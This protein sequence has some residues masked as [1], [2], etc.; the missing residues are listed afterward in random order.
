MN[1]IQQTLII[2]LIS[3]LSITTTFAQEQYRGGLRTN[4]ST[5]K[6]LP[7][8]SEAYALVVATDQYDNFEDLNNPIYDAK[9]VAEVLRNDYDF[10]V[11]LLLSPS[12]EELLDA[13]REYHNKLR[14]NDRFMLYLAGHGDYEDKYYEEGFLI[15]KETKTRGMD[16]SLISYLPFHRLKALTENLPSQQALVV[17]DVCFGGAF[18]DKINKGRGVSSNQASISAEDFLRFQL[19]EKNRYVL[20]SG[21][22]TAVADGKKGE[23]SPFAGAF[24]NSLKGHK[25]DSIV[26]AGTVKYDLKTL[27]S[28][29]I[30]GS[31]SESV[32]NT[33]FVFKS[34]SL[35]TS[36][37]T[38]MQ[39]AIDK[40]MKYQ[41]NLSKY[42]LDEP[43][44]RKSKE[45]ETIAK[46]FDDAAVDEENIEAMFW[47]L[48]MENQHDQV[49]MTD[50]ERD[51]FS[52][53]VVTAFQQE[54]QEGIDT[55][56]WQLATIQALGIRN[57]VDDSE[58][59]TMFQRAMGKH[60]V[61][62]FYF[63]GHFALRQGHLS[64]AYTYFK[65]GAKENDPFCQYELGKLKYE[66]RDN[67]ELDRSKEGYRIDLEKASDSGLQRATD[68]L[69]MMD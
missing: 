50:S 26:T 69:L 2:G 15:L 6:K 1:T 68:Y 23:H 39:R 34:K 29:P 31:F 45:L 58:I 9:G 11:D 40:Y 53:L 14:K 4:A 24:I 51:Y 8:Q 46:I 65:Q 55:H 27:P 28:H 25:G 38:L 19:E 47:K 67:W 30:L 13:V 49:E 12:K 66:N 44:L 16:P 33:E 32:G 36:T 37:S 20:S 63:G 52:K 42:K 22:L 60:K 54:Q 41:M 48:I 57:F 62:S 21:R 61:K 56:L 17:V 35:G 18:N 5:K 10:K 59:Y 7:V 64:K 43:F 3:L